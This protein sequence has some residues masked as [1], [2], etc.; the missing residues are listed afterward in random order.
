MIGRWAAI[1]R[2]GVAALAAG[3]V[4]LSAMAAHAQGWFSSNDWDSIV[5]RAREEGT[6]VISGPL[7][8]AWREP[9]MSFQRDYPGITV[10]YKPGR[11]RDFWPTLLQERK[12]EEYRWDVRVGPPDAIAYQLARQGG[13]LAPVRDMLTREEIVSDE[14]WV[15]GFDSLFADA[16][17]RFV[18]GFG[19]ISHPVAWVNRD[20]VPESEISAMLDLRDPRWRG[21]ISFGNFRSGAAMVNLG[22]LLSHPDYGEDFVRDLLKEQEAVII[23]DPRKQVKMLVNGKYPIAIAIV[24]TLLN[25]LRTRGR[26]RNVVPLPGLRKFTSGSG[27]LVAIKDAPHPNAAKVFAN[28]I[29]SRKVQAR[30]ASAVG[31]NSRRTDV[32]IGNSGTAVDLTVFDEYVSSQNEEMMPFYRKVVELAAEMM[33]IKP[34]PRTRTSTSRRSRP[35]KGRNRSRN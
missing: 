1:R 16:A 24:P 31:Y 22:A 34:D 35:R 12:G 17:K 32:R 26:A 27:G 3:L 25:R 18:I 29:L 20:V 10:E 9:I 28:W 6:L 33:P 13:T 4:V 8:E 2:L 5:E 7:D 19:L 14:N 23:R 30:I 15:G 21:R 11:H